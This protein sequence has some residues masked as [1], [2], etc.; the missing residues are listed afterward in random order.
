MSPSDSQALAYLALGI[1]FATPRL[2]RRVPAGLRRIGL[3]A[4]DARRR[5]TKRVKVDQFRPTRQTATVTRVRPL[6]VA[7]RD[8][9]ERHPTVGG[10]R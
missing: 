9:Y 10:V 5:G 4:M 2:W 8:R 7:N 3:S 1:T 6:R